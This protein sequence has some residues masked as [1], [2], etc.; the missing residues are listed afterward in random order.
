MK[1]KFKGPQASHSAALAGPDKG[2][3]EAGSSAPDEV[4]SGV[5]TIVP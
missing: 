5:T 2:G 1:T 3:S 4:S